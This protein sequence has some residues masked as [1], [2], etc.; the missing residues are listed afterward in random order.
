[1]ADDIAKKRAALNVGDVTKIPVEGDQFDK[2]NFEKVFSA[3]TKGYT[4][5]Y[6]DRH[7]EK[8]EVQP[9]LNVGNPNYLL[10]TKTIKVFPQ[11]QEYNKSGFYNGWDDPT[12]I[13]ISSSE[14]N[15]YH[16]PQTVGH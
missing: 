8:G 5:P 14:L 4:A 15:P 11:Y 1:M 6:S 2:P 10:G 16:L 9:A 7:F 12:S 3:V 13:N